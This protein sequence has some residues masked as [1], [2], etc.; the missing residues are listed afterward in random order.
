MALIKTKLFFISIPVVFK[1]VERDDSFFKDGLQPQQEEEKII[2]GFKKNC[3]FLSS[4]DTLFAGLFHKTKK[5]NNVFNK[6]KT[7]ADKR[8]DKPEIAARF[9][10]AEKRFKFSKKN[11]ITST[12]SPNGQTQSKWQEK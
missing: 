11:I 8:N 5:P 2:L 1:K 10:L 3:P 7:S 6:I 4:S 12:T 9:C